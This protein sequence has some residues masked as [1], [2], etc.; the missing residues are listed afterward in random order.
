M[1]T[2]LD[3]NSPDFDYEAWRKSQNIKP[4]ITLNIELGGESEDE[5]SEE[6]KGEGM[7]KFDSEEDEM[8]PEDY[9]EFK[10]KNGIKSAKE[11]LKNNKLFKK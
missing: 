10:K 8:E 7:A 2:K 1:N 9:K 3:P 11:V 4:A 6:D 5:E